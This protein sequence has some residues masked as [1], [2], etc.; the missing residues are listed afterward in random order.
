MTEFLRTLAATRS[1][2]DA[3]QAVGMSRQSAYKLR[4]R[5]K[6][7]KFDSAWDAALDSSL[8][9]VPYDLIERI[10][11]GVEVPHF[12]RGKRIGT[13]R[14]YDGRLAVALLKFLETAG[15]PGRGRAGGGLARFE[16]LLAEIEAG[17]AGD[18]AGRGVSRADSREVSPPPDTQETAESR[19]SRRHRLGDTVS[20]RATPPRA[21]PRGLNNPRRSGTV[22]AN[23]GRESRT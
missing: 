19:R 7:Q 8:A 21:A 23:T 17:G 13:S 9:D 20:P 10:V 11:Q 15:R 22:S 6:G 14:R 5:L 12:Y 4:R 16:T 3:A 2:K 18:A 1:V